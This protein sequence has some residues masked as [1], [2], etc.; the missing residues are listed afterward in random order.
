MYWKLIN[1]NQLI[2]LDEVNKLKKDKNPLYKSF[3]EFAT[4]IK[5]SLVFNEKRMGDDIGCVIVE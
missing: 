1:E 2:R 5:P 4:V 3:S